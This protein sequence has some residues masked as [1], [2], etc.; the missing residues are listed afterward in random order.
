MVLDLLETTTAAV[1]SVQSYV[2]ALPSVAFTTP[3]TPSTLPNSIPSASAST[4]PRSSL[5]TFTASLPTGTHNELHRVSSSAALQSSSLPATSSPLDPLLQLRK[6]S[7]D[8]LGALKE[9]EG[10]YRLIPS[11]EFTTGD[12]SESTP[13]L[14]EVDED[15]P[16]LSPSI[17]R[18][19]SGWDSSATTSEQAEEVVDYRTDV[20]LEDLGKELQVVRRFVEVV[21]EL[22][23]AS[24][25]SGA[26]RR[27]M[28]RRS[29][30][31]E[32]KGVTESDSVGQGSCELGEHDVPTVVEPESSSRADERRQEIAE[33]EE[34][35]GDVSD[36]EEPLPDWAQDQRFTDPLGELL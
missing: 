22:L 35:E 18:S 26:G 31:G 16:A 24:T 8:L 14:D 5:A 28:T 30:E 27:K 6:T 15:T 3:T 23:R 13:R 9:M 20:G 19:G 32:G 4:R 12:E 7:L 33:R 11:V 21:D 25:K 10:R 2:V 36:E 29:L 34:S 17:S 1:R